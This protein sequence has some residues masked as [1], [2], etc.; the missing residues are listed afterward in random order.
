[1]LTQTLMNVQ[2]FSVFFPFI[3]ATCIAILGIVAIFKLDALVG[4]AIICAVFLLVINPAPMGSLNDANLAAVKE[5]TQ[6]RVSDI[7]QHYQVDFCSNQDGFSTPVAHKSWGR[8]VQPEELILCGG[9]D[10][11]EITKQFVT[12][13]ERIDYKIAV[14]LK[15]G[16]LQFSETEIG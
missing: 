12:D 11:G 9:D 6:N 2:D 5:V 4:V 7:E 14:A 13:G 10:F 15:W 1:M 16:R 8:K 3:L